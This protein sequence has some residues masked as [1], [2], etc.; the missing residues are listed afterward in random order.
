M[1]LF[2]CQHCGQLLF[3]ENTQCERCRYVLGYLPHRTVLSARTQ[4]DGDRW[5]PLAAPDQAFRFCANAAHDACNWMVQADGFDS[6]CRACRL[7]RTIP[8]LDMPGQLPCWQRLEGAKHRLVYGLLR[9]GL[10]LTSKDENPRA[11]VAFNFLAGLGSTLREIAQAITG[12]SQSLIT[13]GIAE[14]NGAQREHH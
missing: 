4:K 11:G 10:P 2:E 3:F 7:N 5:L 1:K 14:A 13:I 9:F 8:N 12:H 6:F